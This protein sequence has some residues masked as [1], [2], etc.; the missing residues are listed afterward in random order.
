M[1]ALIM[2]G[3]R[4]ISLG[5]PGEAFGGLDRGPIVTLDS[6]QAPIA[7]DR[8]KQ[9]VEYDSL[10]HPKDVT[11]G[12]SV[13]SQRRVTGIMEA[14][15]ESVCLHRWRS[16]ACAPLRAGRAGGVGDVPVPESAASL[17]P[18]WTHAG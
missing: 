16:G 14:S 12:N 4:K 13:I 10:C 11:F 1:T 7:F 3:P 2:K 6:G 5:P 18:I 8:I 9:I 15:I 17:P